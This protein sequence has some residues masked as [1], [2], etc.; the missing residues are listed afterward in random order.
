MAFGLFPILFWRV[1]VMPP[2]KGI[3]PAIT[4]VL[5][6][7]YSWQNA[8]N[9]APSSVG[10]GWPIA[11][12]RMVCVMIGTSNLPLRR[13]VAGVADRIKQASASRSSGPIYLRRRRKKSQSDGRTRA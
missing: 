7:G 4:S 5:V 3:L 8:H 9:P 10:W 11:W 2:M 13:S 6:I 12:R 1:H